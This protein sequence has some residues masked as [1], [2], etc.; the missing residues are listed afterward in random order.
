MKGYESLPA[1]FAPILSIDLQKQ[2]KLAVLVNV[3]AFVIAV[4]MVVIGIFAV[5]DAKLFDFSA[6]YGV[7]FGRLGVLVGGLFAYIILHELVHGIFMRLFSRQRVKYGFT[8]LYAFAGSDAYFDK[9]SYIIIALAPVIVWGAVLA[10][11]CALL[12]PL[13]FWP[14]Y[15]IQIN[16]FSGAAGDFYVTARFLFLPRDILVRDTGVAMT[17]FAKSAETV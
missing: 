10:V 4:L 15:L 8:G 17:V 13:W 7:Y 11:L 16:N 2:K 6:G 5:P 12:P 3:L 9:A 1:D 14:V